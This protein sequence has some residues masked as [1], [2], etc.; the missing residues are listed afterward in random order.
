M[1]RNRLGQ[2][3]RNRHM[4]IE[5]YKLVYNL[6]CTNGQNDR[7]IDRC[8]VVVAVP[9]RLIDRSINTLID[10]SALSHSADGIVHRFQC[11]HST[12]P[13]LSFPARSPRHE[14]A[15]EGVRPER[16]SRLPRQRPFSFFLG[17]SED[18]R[19]RKLLQMQEQLKRMQEQMR[20]LVEESMNSK[21]RKSKPES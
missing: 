17:D 20:I 12:L 9:H 21:S 19:E 7:S 4:Y 3:Y 10:R 15:L 2:R 8:C 5:V 13:A 14:A 1:P 18:E 16:N 11:L 6:R